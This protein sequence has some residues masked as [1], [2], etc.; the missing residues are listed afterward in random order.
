MAKKKADAAPERSR[1]AEYRD[2]KRG[3]P[4]R[5]LKPHGT[6]AAARRHEYY[7]EPKCAACAAA[8]KEHQAQMYRQ[9]VGR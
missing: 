2:R 3:G 7:G 6:I 5:Q 9:R 1:F 4:P 8:W